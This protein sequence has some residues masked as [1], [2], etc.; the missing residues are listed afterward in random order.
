VLLVAC[1]GTKPE[2]PSVSPSATSPKTSTPTASLKPLKIGTSGDLPP[3][4]Y[5]GKGGKLKGFDIELMDAIASESGYKVEYQKLPLDSL[6]PSLQT[7]KINGVIS[8]ITVT[9]DREKIANFSRPYF[10]I[11]L[12]IAVSEKNKTIKNIESLKG[13]AIGVES[14]T[15]AV[16]KAQNLPHVKV[17]IFKTNKEVLEALSQGKVDAILNETAMLRLAMDKGLK[18]IKIV[19]E[20]PTDQYY[21]IALPKDSK[22]L[23]EINKGLSQVIAKGDYTI[24]YKKYWKSEPPKLPETLP[25]K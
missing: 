25:S 17:K 15:I 20:I 23:G 11:K 18:G 1:E 12:A 2:K 24:L 13:N 16:R 8:A 9:P 21:A 14:G 10:Q 19:G 6:L 4:S 7:G 22:N 3:F 5:Y